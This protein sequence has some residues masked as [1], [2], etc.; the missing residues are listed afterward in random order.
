[1]AVHALP[2]PEQVKEE[3]RW[4]FTHCQILNKSKTS[5]GGRSRTARSWTSQLRGQV[6]GYSRTARSW[7]S[8]SKSGSCSR[9]ARSW[10]IQRGGQVAVHALPDPDSSPTWV[11]DR[12]DSR[13]DTPGRIWLRQ[14]AAQLPGLPHSLFGCSG[15]K[16][17]IYFLS[18]KFISNFSLTLLPSNLC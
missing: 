11:V 6:H 15:H 14:P 7:T 4:P 17:K 9:T 13:Q 10:T 2:D 16:E 8:Q 18:I 3:V 1:M 5:S 12:S